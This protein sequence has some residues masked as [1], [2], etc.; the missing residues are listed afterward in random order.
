MAEPQVSPPTRR[1][2]LAAAELLLSWKKPLLLS[3]TSPDG[4]AMGCLI[5]MD[6]ILRDR[7]GEPVT[8]LY[9]ACPPRY[10][11]MAG[12]ARAHVLAG[13]DDPVLAGVDGVLIMDTCAHSQLG[14]MAGWLRGAT[15]PKLV[16]D[17]H[18]TRDAIADS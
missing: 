1:D 7:G 18:R 2:F 6:A 14:M 9:D 5:A 16:V 8:A 10:A 17:H 4:D 11:S 3:H 13:L 15:I 12:A